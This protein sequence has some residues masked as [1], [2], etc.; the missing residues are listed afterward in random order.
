M[1]HTHRFT[2]GHF[3]W[4]SGRSRKCCNNWFGWVPIPWLDGK[5]VITSFGIKSRY[6]HA[7]IF[8]KVHNAIGFVVWRRVIWTAH[9]WPFNSACPWNYFKT[10][11]CTRSKKW[12]GSTAKGQVLPSQ[13]VLQGE[14]GEIFCKQIEGN[15]GVCR[16]YHKCQ[17]SRGSMYKYDPCM[18]WSLM[19]ATSLVF[20]NAHMSLL[21][22]YRDQN[23]LPWGNHHRREFHL[24]RLL[25]NTEKEE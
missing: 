11:A 24:D 5:F 12:W 18:C 21:R 6:G 1:V 4:R 9:A 3:F 13:N 10:L 25:R 20:P 14:E 23:R 16:T 19:F 8:D 2:I 17:C 15:K 7:A 22:P